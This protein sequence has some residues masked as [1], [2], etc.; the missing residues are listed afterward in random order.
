MAVCLTGF[1]P[2]KY[3]TEP[4]D[5][6]EL[7]ADALATG[8]PGVLASAISMVARANGATISSGS[9]ISLR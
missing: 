4:E 8:D 1:D 9:S 2:A 6:A 5:Q 7:L 3:L